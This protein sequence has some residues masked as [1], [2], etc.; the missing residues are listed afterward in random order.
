MKD[1]E[2]RALS[3]V[4]I[5]AAGSSLCRAVLSIKTELRDRY[6]STSALERQLR[7][8]FLQ[9]DSAFRHT[10]E[11]VIGLHAAPATR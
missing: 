6:E 9:D 7:S 5:I 11:S 3:G 2:A 4:R 1:G 8:G 10:L